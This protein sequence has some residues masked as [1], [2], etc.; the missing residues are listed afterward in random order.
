MRRK[1]V[2]GTVVGDERGPGCL[3]DNDRFGFPEVLVGPRGPVESST[4]LES[5]DD[6]AFDRLPEPSEVD[7]CLTRG[8]APNQTDAGED[9][10]MHLLGP[11]WLAR[12]S[13]D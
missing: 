11:A 3:R 7:D 12:V 9:L 4:E 2:R 8:F 5:L 13:V 6:V 1:I 10:T